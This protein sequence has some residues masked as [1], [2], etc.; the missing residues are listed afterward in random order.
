MA[1]VQERS[2]KTQ[3]ATRYD[4]VVEAQLGKARQRIRSLDV[5]VAVLGLLA[6]TMA[7]G[8]VMTVLDR[9]LGLS[10]LTRQLAFAGFALAA[11]TYLGC[12]VVRP[13]TRRI[14]PYF[15]AR[16]IE[17]TIPGAK[18]SVV[19]WLDLQDQNLPS[20]IR[21]AVSHR[22]AKDLQKAS[23][24]QAISGR[25]A[26]GA[27]GAVGAMLLAVIVLFVAVGPAQFFSYLKRNF[28]PFGFAGSV[29]TRTAITI[30]HPDPPDTAVP[31]GRSV[32]FTVH[33]AGLVP[34]A[35]R[36][37][38]L[39]LLYRYRQNDPYEA[40]PL[41][42]ENPHD[43]RRWVTTIPAFQVQNGFWYRISGGDDQTDEYRVDVRSQPLIT[44]YEAIYHYRPYLHY[45]D[46]TQN[47]P[48]L[49]A[50][51]GTEVTLLVRTNR[52]VK[53]GRLE[54]EKAKRTLPAE[55]VADDPTALRFRLVLE[56][57]DRYRIFF[58]STDGETNVEPMAYT[59]DV[60]PDYPP[61]VKLTRPEEGA[62]TLA[63]NATL[64][65]EGSASDDIGVK[66]L[67][68]RMQVVDGPELLP[69]VYREGKSFQLTG[70]GYPQMLEYLDA[71]E[72]GK[73][74]DKEGKPFPLKPGMVIEYW[75]EASDNCDFPGPNVAS[76]KPRKKL[77]I[78]EPEMDQQRLDEQRQQAQQQK[79]Q[80]E[81]KQDERISK[82]DQ[83]RQK[84]AQAGNQ[85][86]EARDPNNN[87]P[88]DS[89]Q[90]QRDRETE[91]KA[92]QLRRGLE[93]R[94]DRQEGASKG[95]PRPDA[96]GEA[97]DGGKPESQEGQDRGGAKKDGKPDPKQPPAQ[98]KGAGDKQPNEQANAGQGRGQGENTPKDQ[99]PG[100]ARGE[101][102]TENAQGKGP[103][104][105]A[106]AGK[107]PQGAPREGGQ[108]NQ[109]D[110]SAQ[111]QAKSA[112]PEKRD[113]SDAARSGSKGPDQ[114][115][116]AQAR[117][118]DRAES[119]H[120]KPDDVQ[121]LRKDLQGGDQKQ[122]Q[123]AAEKLDQIS[124]NASDAQARDAARQ[125]LE[126]AD[127]LPNKDAKPQDAAQQAKDLKNGNA[128]EQREAR[129]QL[130]QMARNAKDEKTREAAQK[131]L[132][133][134]EKRP[135]EQAKP[136]DVSRQAKE[137]RSGDP[138]RQQQGAQK[139]DEMARNANDP[140]VKEAARQALEKAEKKPGQDATPEDVA[141]QQK[142]LQ[143]GDS[144]QQRD[145]ADR[146]QQLARN[147]QDDK[148]REAARKALEERAK[149]MQKEQ[150]PAQAKE[151]PPK[152][153]PNAPPPSSPKKGPPQDAQT[154]TAKENTGGPNTADHGQPKDGGREPGEELAQEKSINP[155]GAR[156]PGTGD[157]PAEAPIASNQDIAGGPG[158]ARHQQR[159]GSLQLDD[160]KKVDKKMLD[161]LGWTPEQLAN[162]RKAYEEL[163]KRRQAEARSAAEERPQGPQRGGQLNNVPVQQVKPSTGGPVEGRSLGRGQP[164]P[165]Y[166]DAAREFSRR[167]NALDEVPE[168]K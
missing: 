64:N 134:A 30:L 31:D 130:E 63:A 137:M 23:L 142:D 36:P 58:T 98:G 141:R 153:G 164:P 118:Q 149:E 167:L 39:K 52:A 81:A 135:G 74:K 151:Q 3:A 75:L 47:D 114:R 156:L 163:V 61:Q 97:K 148:T 67:A 50:L 60:I 59:I 146:L 49:K 13:L 41:E 7:Y 55:L 162:Y 150:S 73:V 136:D 165:G 101:Q 82:E 24:D 127:Q 22:A 70:G 19:N 42:V 18:N 158:D 27:G 154:G 51:R 10:P 80:H 159:G 111:G 109:G 157:A 160:F 9:W 132:D 48:N 100:Q 71:I 4:A 37:D 21:G 46:S 56:Q 120:A 110:P 131:A 117:E 45:P 115:A 85:P 84:D 35:R 54:L 14:N 125:A 62:I 83:E 66:G 91:E 11:L 143:Q 99:P 116:E 89:A 105:N 124:R 1:T 26:I 40:R 33:V 121:Q 122:Q 57:D 78:G 20:A 5:A 108:G 133:N 95:D 79:K 92:E 25:R 107:Q 103:G 77:T 138:K 72:L 86:N 65:V 44:R 147:A 76:S 16:Q 113:G 87:P 43:G 155:S 166:Q 129:E 152:E 139:L 102:P 104:S 68:L 119:R 15:A 123:R 32:T 17:Q 28:S 29:P 90:Q 161:E 69:K 53:E 144:Q 106:D 6:G 112:P 12:F 126:K 168:K 38:A 145:A 96:K 8:L 94:Q 93:K 88:N 140:R 128:G 34:D 2:A